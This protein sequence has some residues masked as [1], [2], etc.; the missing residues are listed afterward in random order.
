MPLPF[1]PKRKKQ[2]LTLADWKWNLKYEENPRSFLPA[3]LSTDLSFLDKVQIIERI[4]AMVY[5]KTS[6]FEMLEG[7]V[8]LHFGDD[9]RLAQLL[10]YKLFYTDYYHKRWMEWCK[11]VIVLDFTGRWIVQREIYVQEKIQALKK[12]AELSASESDE[13]KSIA[14]QISAC[15]DELEN[16]NGQYWSYHTDVWGKEGNIPP[17]PLHRGYKACRKNPNWYLLSWL[18][19]DCAG[20]GGCCGRDRGC[21]E[22]PRNTHRAFNRGHCTNACGCCIRTRRIPDTVVKVE[23]NIDKFPFDMVELSNRYSVHINRAYIW[24]IEDWEK[25]D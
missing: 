12:A 7:E 17:G 1:L 18:R 20:R 11:E 2:V 23:D 25:L 13:Q 3:L 9:I 5:R 15:K 14:P 10:R 22:R 6:K 24:G 4:S 19:Q 21:C 16:L 8:R